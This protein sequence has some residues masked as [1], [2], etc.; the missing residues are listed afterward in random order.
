LGLKELRVLKGFKMVINDRV[1]EFLESW[2]VIRKTLE[3]LTTVTVTL[4]EEESEGE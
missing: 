1:R 4:P 3:E 2:P